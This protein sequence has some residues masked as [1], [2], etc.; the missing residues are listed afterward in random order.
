MPYGTGYGLAPFGYGLDPYGDPYRLSTIGKLS[1]TL[2]SMQFEL[3]GVIDAESPSVAVQSINSMVASVQISAMMEEELS[4]S[5][6]SVLDF[7][8]LAGGIEGTA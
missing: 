3:A 2:Y 6:T 4:L 8:V 7:N 1:A 5:I